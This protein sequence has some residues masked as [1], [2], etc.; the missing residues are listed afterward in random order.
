M[1]RGSPGRPRS[2]EAQPPN[3]KGHPPD[4]HRG[5]AGARESPLG[6]VRRQWNERARAIIGAFFVKGPLWF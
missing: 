5:K 6:L 4:S 3:P 2:Y 1:E